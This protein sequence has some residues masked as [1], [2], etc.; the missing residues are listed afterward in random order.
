MEGGFARYLYRLPKISLKS[1][2]ANTSLIPVA[3]GMSITAKLK[4]SASTGTEIQNS[5]AT[6]T[7]AG[8]MIRIIMIFSSA[9]PAILNSCYEHNS[10]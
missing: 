3:E 10:R 2:Y 5:E 7:R 1:S 8:V 9:F 4:L 6:Q